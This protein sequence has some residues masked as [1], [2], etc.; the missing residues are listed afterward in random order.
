MGLSHPS[1]PIK[2]KLFVPF[3]QKKP[4][5]LLTI[6]ASKTLISD[7]R[8]TEP[9]MLSISSLLALIGLLILVISVILLL[10]R[11]NRKLAI[12]SFITGLLLVF[13]P[14]TLIYLLFN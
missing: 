12:A 2:F 14:R 4:S 1:F 11:R 6:E 7:D 3:L 8:T 13:V 5:C 9:D 10:T